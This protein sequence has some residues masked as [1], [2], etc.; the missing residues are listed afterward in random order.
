MSSGYVFIPPEVCPRHALAGVHISAWT[1]F[2]SSTVSWDC[3]ALGKREEQENSTLFF[4]LLPHLTSP[5]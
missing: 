4:M 2:V 1:S 3:E 5:D